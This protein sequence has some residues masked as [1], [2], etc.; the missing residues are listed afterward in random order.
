MKRYFV[1]AL[2]WQLFALFVA[3]IVVAVLVPQLRLVFLLSVVAVIGWY[4]TI[5]V[6]SN[7]RL[8]PELRKSI[9][10]ITLA[11]LFVAVYL[12]VFVLVFVPQ[13]QA[14]GRMPV[15][16]APLHG[17]AVGALFYGF[18]F[19]SKQFTTLRE[20]RAVEF[21][22]AIVPFLLL[23]FFPIGVWFVQPQVNE[24]LDRSSS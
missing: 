24:L 16:V 5:G 23:W 4:W 14:Q 22:E 6:E 3:P 17:L 12:A 15:I 21:L 10:L 8:S 18:W 9:A 13:A 20:K 19:V 2:P 1:R 11:Y 7:N